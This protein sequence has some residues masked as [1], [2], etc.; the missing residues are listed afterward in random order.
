MIQLTK[1][2]EKSLDLCLK[3]SL[4]DSSKILGCQLSEFKV[5]RYSKKPSRRDS[6]SVDFAWKTDDKLRIHLGLKKN[7]A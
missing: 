1:A 6:Y 4:L 2:E 5:V 7:Q 3:K